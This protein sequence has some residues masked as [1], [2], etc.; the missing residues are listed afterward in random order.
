MRQGTERP[1]R[2]QDGA[3]GSTLRTSHV[4]ALAAA[5]SMALSPADA[6][7]QRSV[8]LAE[9][10]DYHFQLGVEAQTRAE[11]RVALGHY[12]ASQ[13]L[14]PN[15]N[16][17]F[18]IAVCYEALDH[19]LQAFRHYA[20]YL[21]EETDPEERRL[22][23][24][25]LTRLRA[26]VSVVR[27]ESEPAGATVYV[28]RRDLGVRGT[29][30]LVLALDG[31]THEVM[32][33]LPGHLPEHASV[34]AVE[35]TETVVER[36]LRPRPGYLSIEGGPPGAVAVIGGDITAQRPLPV[37][38]ELDPGSYQ[39]TIRAPGHR[40]H[41]ARVAVESGAV[42]RLVPELELEGG[43]ALFETSP[44]GALVELDGRP[45]GFTP[46][47][48]SDVDPGEHHAVLSREGYI[49]TAID[50]HVSARERAV[51]RQ[52][53]SR[54]DEFVAASRQPV[55]IRD[56][57]A[58]V[59]VVSGEE[60]RAFGYQSLWDAIGGLRGIY[61]SY[62]LTYASVG[63]R[64]FSRPQ[65]YGNR[66][67]VLQDGH[68]MNDDWIGSSYVGTDF[69][70]DLVDVSRIEVVRGPNSVLYGS[71]AVLGVLHVVSRQR[72]ETAAPY[73]SLLVDSGAG[74]LVRL[75]V[76]AGLASSPHSGAWL[77]VGMGYARGDDY[78]FPEL[79]AEP[80][81]GADTMQVASLSGRAWDRD[82]SLDVSFNLRDKRIPTAPFD[83]LV[84]DDGTRALDGRGAI[85]ARW[86]PRL[87]ATTRLLA[88]A[89]V[90]AYSFR[91]IYRQDASSAP[92]AIGGSLDTRWDGVWLGAEGRLSLVPLE[93]L[94]LSV[95]AEARGSA[96]AHMD[97]RLTERAEPIL[98]AQLPF[99]G[100]AVHALADVVPTPELRISVGGRYDYVSTFSDG[101]LS[102]R[103]AVVARPLTGTVIRLVGASAF[104]A[105]SI[106][107]LHNQDD[108][109]TVPPDSLAPERV[110]TVE[111]EV[112][113]RI[114]DVELIGAVFYQVTDDLILT[115]SIGDSQIQY[116][117]IGED[118]HTVGVE[119]EVRKELREGWM[120]AAQYSF[121]RTRIADLMA[122]GRAVMA[123]SPEHMAS[124]RAIATIVPELLVVAT[125]ARVESARLARQT[126]EDASGM[127]I[128]R[129][130]SAD[131][132]VVIDVVISGR[133]S[134]M[135]L[136]YSVGV[137]NLLDWQYG[138]PAG[139]DLTQLLVPQAGRSVFAQ[140]Q[141]EMP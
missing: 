34:E 85:E 71:N 74:G 40:A 30:P 47:A 102:P 111:L 108:D 130:R 96:Y 86:E 3:G 88:R 18:N 58:S 93:W 33:E 42:E 101:A 24:D 97:Y 75:R 8:D 56:V 136:S 83:T 82:F 79:R 132:P 19:P 124:I 131:V 43:S 109:I 50:L 48:V 80:I 27:I 77:S 39:I 61:Q 6:S 29:T 78:R 57:P 104:R 116:R 44:E 9:E 31:G 123:N 95:G 107:E 49:T 84:G 52:T 11:Y 120:I 72:W 126:Y 62:D 117:N 129:Q 81:V 112:S 4:L 76:G 5:A 140:L 133:A 65:D 14:A 32:L 28:D 98:D 90:D 45:V 128:S 139:E 10:A 1:T 87:D 105:P 36:R 41:T 51:V 94:E 22:A 103:L 137:R 67:L 110:W 13:R 60:I 114:G 53:L 100:L 115:D 106:Y 23:E 122:E 119:V 55:S 25:A 7:A 17:V 69:R 92:D 12:L 141:L 73:A 59:S 16:V 26:R 20:D 121:Q 135:G 54:S 134:Q 99:M 63:I 15:A 46:L 68:A 21:A 38:L 35:G 91:G 70:S 113:Q 125:R 64:G 138:L 127:E 2:T 66:V 89:Y 37:E 118:I